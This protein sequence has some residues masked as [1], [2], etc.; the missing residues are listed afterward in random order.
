MKFY[1]IFAKGHPTVSHFSNAI[2]HQGLN[3]GV[4]ASTHLW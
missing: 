2:Y 4:T 3:W 1:G